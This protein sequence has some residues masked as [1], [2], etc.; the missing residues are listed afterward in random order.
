MKS[1]S[2][3]ILHAILIERDADC[4]RNNCSLLFLSRL[5]N[6][7]SEGD[8][9]GVAVE[10]ALFLTFSTFFLGIF[11]FGSACNEHGDMRKC[12][13]CCFHTSLCPL[14]SPAATLLAVRSGNISKRLTSWPKKTACVMWHWCRC[15]EK[16]TGKG[17]EGFDVSLNQQSL[18][19]DSKLEETQTNAQHK[20]GRT[21]VGNNDFRQKDEIRT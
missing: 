6:A 3:T 21:F 17:S 12:C 5:L 19:I 7:C 8:I 2:A 1:T 16:D 15:R 20:Q 11:A 9:C 4:N 10:P 13:Q 18:K 14:C